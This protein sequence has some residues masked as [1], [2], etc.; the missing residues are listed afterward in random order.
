MLAGF[1]GY[2]VSDPL[3]NV[4]S[5]LQGIRVIKLMLHRIRGLPVSTAVAQQAWARYD[6]GRWFPKELEKANRC[7]EFM[8]NGVKLSLGPQGALHMTGRLR[9]PP[10]LL[11]HGQ[12]KMTKLW[13]V[14]VH[15]S[16][17]Q[18]C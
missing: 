12:A 2:L 9:D 3:E 5:Y 4:A 18:H 6:Q 8:W 1:A 16:Q 14:H 10:R 15:E 13:I 11:L 17:L 7:S